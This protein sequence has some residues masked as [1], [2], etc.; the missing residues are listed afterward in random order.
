MSLL[1]DKI[2]SAGGYG[3]LNWM[4]DAIYLKLI[5]QL[6][7]GKKLNLRNPKTFNEKLQW[8]KIHDRNPLYTTMVDK[9]EAKK[10]VADII[11][12]EHI[13][14]TL[15]V[16]DSFDDIDFDVLPKQFVL[17]CTHD[18][19]GLVICRDKAKLDKNTAR[20]KI[21]RSMKH[22]YFWMGREWPYKNV[23][24][25]I[26][27]EKYMENA[28]TKEL[29]DYKFFCFDGMAKCMKRDFDRFVEHH[30]N[31]YNNNGNLLKFGEA[32]CSPV[33]DAD[34]SLPETFPQMKEFVEK[35]N[36]EKPFL[37]ADFYDVE[38]NVYFG[39]LTFYPAT[40]LGQFTSEERDM[41]LG[42]W[43]PVPG[44]SG[45]Y[46]L[47]LNDC[48]IRFTRNGREN[49]KITL[50][51]TIGLTDYKFYC[52]NG[53]PRY[54]YISKGLENHETACISF[55][56]LD[57][58]LAE[59]GR[60]DYRPFETLPEKPKNYDKMLKICGMLAEK[61]GAF[62]RVDLYEINEKIYFSELTF[63]PCSGLMP[64]QPVEW[65]EQLGSFL[66]LKTEVSK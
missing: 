40:G 37:R 30:A 45:G 54:L 61:A 51:K 63:S 60:S 19:G 26:I 42:K 55:L 62:L 12:E 41:K 16:W 21:E 1:A 4:S 14:P 25:R 22:N 2:M 9:F 56:T 8:L 7:M 17:K 13:I 33:Y 39:E 11:G 6:K 57:W 23:K 65:D 53:K 38:G 24:P 50:A 3:L 64:F 48:I 20:M 5:Y 46:V 43:L 29:R 59:F 58:K 66:D 36:A 34:V 49:D 18:S 15:G 44:N 52:F 31:Y 10:Y 47:G 27:A 28:A 35:L 32:I